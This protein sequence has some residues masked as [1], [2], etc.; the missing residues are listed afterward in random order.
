MKK[1]YIQKNRGKKKI[2][3]DG[4]GTMTLMDRKQYGKK[5]GLVLCSDP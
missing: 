4:Y 1:T 2:N 5:T 3:W